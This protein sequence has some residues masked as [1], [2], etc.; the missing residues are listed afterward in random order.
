MQQL[1][2][3]EGHAP[4]RALDHHD[5]AQLHALEGRKPA[6]A[7]LAHTPAPD[8]GVLLA[9]PAVLHL[10]IRAGAIG[11]AHASLPG[12]PSPRASSPSPRAMPTSPRTPI[13][14][15]EGR[16]GGQ[17]HTPTLVPVAAPHPNPLPASG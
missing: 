15:G 16:G 13:A 6:A 11:A 8:G 5:V 1:V 3:L 2:A 7:V 10:R 9:R 12:P 17:R 14:R 4:A